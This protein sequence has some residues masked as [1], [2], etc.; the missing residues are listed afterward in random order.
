[1]SDCYIQD[2]ECNSDEFQECELHFNCMCETHQKNLEP[3]RTMLKC[4]NSGSL[5]LP[6]NTTAGARFTIT[7]VNV[8][9][10]DF[11]KPCIKLE[12]TSDIATRVAALTLDFQVFKQ[13]KGM[14]TPIPIGPVWTF[15][16]LSTIT[17]SNTFSFLVCDCDICNDECCTYSVVVRVA[18]TV[19]V[20]VTTINNALISAFIVDN[21]NTC[22]S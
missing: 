7:T 21:T 18:S 1:M 20:G 14:V 16:R 19:T 13:C 3:N 5:V 4:G 2:R 15:S 22:K 11:K 9:V 17:D 12:F 8:N 10:K 6:V